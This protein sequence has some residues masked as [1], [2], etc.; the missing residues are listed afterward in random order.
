MEYLAHKTGKY[1]QHAAN[2]GE[3]K[4]GPYKVDGFLEAENKAV[5]FLGCY[6]HGCKK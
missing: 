6:F 4:I 2:G 1:I 5:E 3:H